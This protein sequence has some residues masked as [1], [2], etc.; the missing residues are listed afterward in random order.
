MHSYYF[1]SHILILSV[2]KQNTNIFSCIFVLEKM[3]ILAKYT[4][5][6]NFYSMQVKPNAFRG[7][8]V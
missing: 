2:D 5:K 3:V 6:I 7:L 1:I 4:L 8:Q